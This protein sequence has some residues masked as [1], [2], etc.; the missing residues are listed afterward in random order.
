[1]MTFFRCVASVLLCSCTMMPSFAQTTTPDLQTVPAHVAETFGPA[2]AIPAGEYSAELTEAVRVAFETSLAPMGSVSQSTWGSE[3][4]QALSRIV[5]SK[6]PRLAWLVA[7]LLGFTWQPNLSEELSSAAAQLLGKPW[8]SDDHWTEIVDHLIAWDIPE[9]PNYLRA[10]RSMYTTLLHGLENVMVEGDIDWRLVSWGGVSID[11]RAYDE[12]DIP[13]NCIPAVDNPATTSA[14]EAT[15]LQD[16]DIVFGLSVNGEHRAYPRQIMEVREM[17]NDTLG[18]RDLGMPYCTLCGAAQAYFTDTLDDRFA[19]PVLRTS[20]LLFRSNKV[21]YDVNTQSV[22]DTFRGS[23]VT[24]EL[25]EHGVVLPPITVVTT[26]W[27]AWKST[28][29]DTT[30]LDEALALGRNFDFRNGRDADGPI[31]PV[32]DI[33]PRLSPQEDVVAVIAPSGQAIAFS[34]RR[35]ILALGDNQDVSLA[36]VRLRVAAGGLRAE[37][38]DGTVVTS[39]EAFWFAWSQFHPDT[40]VWLGD[41]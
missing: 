23:A 31:F 6:D 41:S 21:M 2:P 24:G 22:F 12:T 9:P 40:L 37:T 20:G 17:V 38:D 19:R 8:H 39:H 15:W 27:G 32:G 16:S 36:G 26:S 25:A 28:Y 7:D 34:R 33:D 3:H 14:A 18:G 4:R 13:C 30:V 35:A 29:P 11:A 1:M 5:A 10:K